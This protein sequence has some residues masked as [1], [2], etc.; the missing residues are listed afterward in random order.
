MTPVF[1]TC[2]RPCSFSLP[3]VL[4]GTEV[5][6]YASPIGESTSAPPQV[7][8]EIAD[9]FWSVS[10]AENHG[11]IH[12]LKNTER[13]GVVYRLH[14]PGKYISRY[15]PRERIGREIGLG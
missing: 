4:S 5:M 13:R 11:C 9:R 12:S 3:G 10:L 15:S 8:P 1:N 2:P 7:G 14:G 6:E